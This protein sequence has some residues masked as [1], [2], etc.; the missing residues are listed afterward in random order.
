MAESFVGGGLGG[1]S[2]DGYLLGPPTSS[3]A[4]GEGRKAQGTAKRVGDFLRNLGKP[5]TEKGANKVLAL[6]KAIASF[7]GDGRGSSGNS[8]A[9]RAR[10]QANAVQQRDAQRSGG[11]ANFAGGF[12][13]SGGAGKAGA[14]GAAAGTIMQLGSMAVAGIDKR[15]DNMY[16]QALSY[17]K[18]SMLYQQTQGISQNRFTN[19]VLQPL[20]QYKLGT[21]GASS[22][23][24]LQAQTGL[25]AQGN[26]RGIAGL[27]A[28]TGFSYSTQD[29]AQMMATLASPQVNNRMTM[30]MGTGMYG[31]GGSQRNM[32]QVIQQVVRSSGLTNEGMVK[33][34]MQLGSISRARLSA[35]GLPEDMQNMVLQYAQEN[36]QFRKKGGKGMY[37]PDDPS[38]QKL[39]GIKGNFANQ[40]EETQRV[41]EKRDVQF[42][43][44]QADNYAR[45]EKNTQ[46]LIKAFGDLE[47]KMAG[48]IGA[49]MNTRNSKTGAFLKGAAGIGLM[50]GGALLSEVGVGVP[51][52]AA[53]A[54]MFASG[55]AGF[56]GG[57]GSDP[58]PG[59]KRD[60]SVGY[61]GKKK[62][63]AEAANIPTVSKLN[64]KFRDRI[65]KMMQDNPAVGV[66]EG[67]RSSITQRQGF[68]QRYNKTSE[69]TGIFW[70]GSY[71][72][73][74][75]GVPPMT[76]P[77]MSMHEI[78]LA[79]DLTGDLDWVQKNASKYGL[80]TF[81]GVNGEPWHVQ[82]A[83]LPD[84]RSAYERE[85][86]KWGLNGATERLDP[87]AVIAGMKDGIVS[88]QSLGGK[89]GGS[90]GGNSILSFSQSSITDSIL[91]ARAANRM[92]LGG[93]GQDGSGGTVS[94]LGS[95]SART[96]ANR[97][98]RTLSGIEVA[99]IF[100]KAGFRGADLVK[101]VA[102]AQRES[103]FVT[104][105]FNPTA[106][107]KDLS[108]GL[109][110]INMRGDLGPAR[111]KQFGLQSNEEL[112]D[113]DVN[114]R[115]AYAIYKSTNKSFGMWG[116]GY[117]GSP[118]KTPLDHT[119]VPQATKYVTAAGFKTTG[120]GDPMPVR[121]MQMSGGGGG[122][123]V[124]GASININ[125]P[126]S[127]NGGG[128]V[129]AHKVSQDAA[130]AI[131]R[132]LKIA[133]MR[134]N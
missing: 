60:Y 91:G 48:V 52:M 127:I 27:R 82:P 126:I 65:L 10:D 101:A 46:G 99:R 15:T 62:S 36:V 14:Y 111:L 106:K 83:E 35:M 89:S 125:V 95:S 100:Y 120:S 109:M 17:D 88:D 108:Y 39:M 26:A 63:L 76:P 41:Q 7:K 44:K 13:G 51:M 113:P 68:L 54:T 77:G 85:G 94:K 69:K 92:N 43:K 73:K 90:S 31:P 20:T 30:T 56:S 19:A 122:T 59:F 81:A 25:S 71:W 87:K 29:M 22:L 75:S 97:K 119:N 38:Q 49:R 18:L 93:G 1:D 98:S 123:Y 55:A 74:K 58:M 131:E 128:G 103:R 134:R 64:P 72:Q 96:A 121:S 86:A 33:G 67:Y 117:K 28:A 114:A 112:Y 130:R 116:G 5:D 23:L 47:N 42:Y 132:E 105:A 102:I 3:S 133:L 6:I 12:T 66:G 21:G 79:A 107:T 61:G 57:T 129:D 11:F 53:G 16:G 50:V 40:Q 37:N 2:D 118:Y 110:Q 24:A 124:E 9:D 32:M 80:K 104:G 8:G 34:A 45:L 70:E 115:A 4:S 78:G 84:G